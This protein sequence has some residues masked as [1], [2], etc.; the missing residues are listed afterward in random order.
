[1]RKRPGVS[2]ANEGVWVH[3]RLAAGDDLKAGEAEKT[4]QLP[5]GLMIKAPPGT[6]LRGPDLLLPLAGKTTA[7]ITYRFEAK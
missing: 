7:T 4:Y 2:E 3:L 6:I 1:M 5:R